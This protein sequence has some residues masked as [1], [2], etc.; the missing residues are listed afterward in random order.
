MVG[1]GSFCGGACSFWSIGK[2][3]IPLYQVSQ[4]QSSSMMIHLQESVGHSLCCPHV[5]Y[6]NTYICAML[7]HLVS[8][9]TIRANNRPWCHSRWAAFQVRWCQLEK[10]EDSLDTALWLC[11]RVFFPLANMIDCCNDERS[12]CQQRI[13]FQEHV[14]KKLKQC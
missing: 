4:F 5:P 14:N 7:E 12:K 1:Q 13:L 9:R 10:D 11:Y 3:G 2:T 6:S 8:R